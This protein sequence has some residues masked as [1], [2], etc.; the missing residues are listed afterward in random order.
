MKNNVSKTWTQ[1]KITKLDSTVFAN[2]GVYTP[3]FFYLKILDLF[4]MF[5]DKMSWKQGLLTSD[6]CTVKKKAETKNS[7]GSS[8]YS[9]SRPPSQFR[10]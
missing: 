10:S 6:I 9:T 2:I 5:W 4:K 7:I 3:T 1:V 8:K